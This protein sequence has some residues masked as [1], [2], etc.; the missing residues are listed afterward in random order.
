MVC[1]GVYWNCLRSSPHPLPAEEE[2]GRL[3]HCRVEVDQLHLCTPG[4]TG[5]QASRPPPLKAPP[6]RQQ[7]R[8]KHAPARPSSCVLL[9]LRQTCLA[10]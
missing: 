4:V 2:V 5:R 6:G 9:L 1:V 8:V 3:I 7:E 10:S